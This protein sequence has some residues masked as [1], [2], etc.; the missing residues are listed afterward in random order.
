MARMNT[1]LLAFNRGEVSKTALAR[2]DLAKLQLATECQVNWAPTVLG[3]AMLRPG[4][5]YVG[6]IFGD[7]PCALVDF[8][9]AADDTSLLELTDSTLRV[10]IND[11]LIARVAVATAVLDPNMSGSGGYWVT[12]DTTS[13]CTATVTGGVAT[14]LAAARGGLARIKQ[15]L[16][17]AGGD[18]NKEHGLRVVVSNGPVTIRIGSAAGLSDYLA[19]TAIDSGT[20]SLTFTPPGA[21][22]YRHI[23]SADTRAKTVTAVAIEAA[24]TVAVPTPWAR[25]DLGN[26]R[27]TQSKDVVFCAAYGKQQYKIERRGPRP[28]ARGWSVVKY[29]SG[30]GPFFEAPTIAANL[31]PSVYEGNGTL[32]CD[33]PFF[34]PGHAGALFQL[35]S[36]GQTNQTVLGA[37]NAFTD[38]IR[39]TGVGN[40]RIFGWNVS[41]SWNGKLTLQRS[42]VGA[43]SAFADVAATT[44]NALTSQD[45]TATLNNVVAWYRVGFK[46]GD[47]VSGN[48]AVFFGQ[49][50]GASG[51]SVGPTAVNAENTFTAALFV[52]ESNPS[53]TI[54]VVG[55]AEA[56]V[57]TVSLQQS[58]VSSSS[59]FSTIATYVFGTLQAA[60]SLSEVISPGL[61]G[62][63]ATGAWF[64]LGI[65]TGNYTSGTV[66]L[67]LILPGVGGVGGS[68]SNG[69]AAAAGGQI[70][71]CRVTGYNSPTSVN[72][73]V[74]SAF[75]S[76]TPTTDWQ[77]GAWSDVQGWPSSI[78]FQED[79][80]WPIGAPALPV[81]GS[82]TNNYTGF[83]ET[84]VNLQT[85]GDAGAILE[86]FGDGPSD[87]VNWGLGLSR[88]LCGRERSIASIRSSSF[89]TPL[90]PTDFAVKD[91]SEQG[92]ARL[93]AAKIGKRGVFVSQSGDRV[94]EL[95]F[96]PQAADYDDNN[97]TRFNTDIAKPG[98]VD[99]AAATQ[100]DTNIYFP[101]ADGEAAALLY[102]PNDE[103][104]AWWRL[105]TLGAF[106]NVRVLPRSGGG[107]DLVYFCVRRIVN[108]VTR[109]FLERL[110]ARTSNAGGLTNLLL[111]CHVAYNGAPATSI[112]LPQLPST[113]VS[114]WA[115]GA[116]IGTGTTNGA[117]L[118]SPLPDSLPHSQIVA[119]LTGATVSYFGA[120]TSTMT[121]PAAYNGVPGEFFADKQPSQRM[122]YLGTLTPVGGTVTLPNGW[123]AASIVGFFG[124]MA[125]LM[126]A[127]LAYGARLGTPLT[128]KKKLD[129]VGLIAYD[130]S[131]TAV[132]F[133]QRFDALEPLPAVEDDGSV[134]ANAVWSEYDQPSIDLPADWDTDSRVCLLGQAPF[135]A[136][137]GAL[138]VGVTTNER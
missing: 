18:Q 55:E 137:L 57:G 45:D 10:W 12:T 88:L 47:Y 68:P 38:P 130:M 114:V 77:E 11:A 100:P 84:D 62:G 17:V 113:A 108:G 27:W 70:G 96:N 4:L 42:L 1:H 132:Q 94:Y 87:R 98:L 134:A 67:T 66:D 15:T 103:V 24:G 78:V 93:M 52:A 91:C 16:S 80:L 120:A 50:A 30:N 22:A 31:T 131:A 8:I 138:V 72:I 39:V 58:T 92:A 71:I 74:I 128:Q 49:T 79:R 51:G 63:G 89:D 106:E 48:A 29:R 83:A 6:E 37:A 19:Q 127:K 136:K 23:D 86:D 59:G 121:V 69:A 133:G 46:Q 40:D 2:I 9:Y 60:L 73:E 85:L 7:K 81:V 14:L 33:K 126:S 65:E 99:I 32:A 112:S 26:V 35:F 76:L 82:Q 124:F 13:G 116:F 41:G 61:A 5:K 111:D 54:S 34:Q 95:F 119:G 3:P 75:S 115:D 129:S 109:R 122:I 123:E 56:F 44:V 21:S 110:T 102:D 107:D 105:M 36:P 25:A 135:P 117:G 28:G 101:R 125:P 97:L 64:R 43:D 90:T 104:T 20:H 118:L 53:L